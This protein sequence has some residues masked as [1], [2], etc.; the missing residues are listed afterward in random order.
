L[1]HLGVRRTVAEGDAGEAGLSRCAIDASN[2][3]RFVID[4]DDALGALPQAA[5]QLDEERALVVAFADEQHAGL[6]SGG[7][8]GPPGEFVRKDRA[9]VETQIERAQLGEGCVGERRFARGETYGANSAGLLLLNKARGGR[10]D[11]ANADRGLHAI[12]DTSGLAE[13]GGFVQ[14]IGSTVLAN[15][16][17][18]PLIAAEIADRLDEGVVQIEDEQRARLNGGKGFV[19]RANFANFGEAARGQ[20]QQDEDEGAELGH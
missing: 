12:P 16:V 14:P 10:F 6:E 2:V 17:V 1:L 15:K 9:F 8:H 3:L 5:E 4:E 13:C 19:K 7:S 11:G 20:R 18:V